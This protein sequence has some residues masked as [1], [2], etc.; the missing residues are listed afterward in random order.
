MW[1]LAQAGSEGAGSAW[2]ALLTFIQ[3]AAALLGQGLVK[4]CN[5]LLPA[6]RSLGED[7]V[8][9]LG[10]LGLLTA[11]L[12]LFDLIAAARRVIWIVVGIG[13]LLLILRIVLWALGVQ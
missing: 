1:F 12:L 4:L 9:P 5:L 8:L 2:Q 13:W 11:V 3:S 7:M 10:Y 6:G